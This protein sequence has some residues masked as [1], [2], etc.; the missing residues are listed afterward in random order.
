MELGDKKDEK[1]IQGKNKGGKRLKHGKALCLEKMEIMMREKD[2]EGNL[3][4]QGKVK[5]LMNKQ[6]EQCGISGDECGIK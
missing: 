4:N 5:E 1:W 3:E 2:M 6:E